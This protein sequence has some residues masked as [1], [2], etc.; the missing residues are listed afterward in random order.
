MD[1]QRV[2]P[3]D[4][5]VEAAAATLKL[6]ADP[7]RLRIVWAL[8]HGSHAVGDLAVHVGAQP[9]AVSQHLAK[10]RLAQL[11]RTERQGTRVL[12]AL[13]NDHLE[14][15]ATEALFHGQHVAGSGHPH[16]LPAGHESRGRA[17]RVRLFPRRHRG[18]PSTAP[19]PSTGPSDEL[20]AFEGVRVERGGRTVLEIDHLAL[21]DAASTAVVGPSG[22]GKSTLLRLC[23][24]LDAPTSGIVRYRGRDLDAF[25]PLVLRQEVAMVFQQPVA[26]DG[27]VADNLREGD[28]S[29]TDREV[30]LALGRVG[31]PEDLA[32]RPAAQ[33]SGGERQRLGLARSLATDPRVLLL[34]EATERAGPG[35]RRTD[36]APRRG[37]GGRGHQRRVGH[38]RPGPGGSCR[39]TGR[40]RRRGPGRPARAGRSGLRRTAPGHGGLPALG[41]GVSTTAIGL[42]GVAASLV[43]VAV[44]ALLSVH[45]RLGLERSI[46][47][48]S[49]R[50]FVQLF[51]IGGALGLVLA[52]GAPLYWSW[53]WVVAMV[54]IGGAT[55]ASRAEEVPGMF[56]LASAA[57]GAAAAASLAVIFGFGIFPLEP[58]TV[59]PSAGMLL[60]NVIAA[61][62]L[63]ARRTVIELAE[64]R[65]QIEVRLSLGQP[66]PAAVRPHVREAL[67]T[68]IGPQIETTKI[69]GLIS[70]PGTMTGLLLAG[71]DPVDAVL[72]QTAVMFLILG[73]VA[74]TSVIIG[75]GVAKRFLTVDHR[76]VIPVP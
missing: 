8:L 32:D 67:R 33:L 6:L 59:V 40:G 17:E 69:V 70:L 64:H 7:T 72:V 48:A 39:R 29:L 44:A 13:V 58:R 41:G 75:R 9:A 76:L 42:G 65:D 10:L 5:Q 15:L 16:T 68:A 62:V 25:D 43:L 28:A 53:L 66:G 14:R 30:E 74:M 36:R 34:D 1:T 38:P 71:V 27:S 35:Q 11:V 2:D 63:A 51:A 45:H 3:S 56:W 31:L 57:L 49:L 18:E 20:F 19:A 60:G 46:A 55:I 12:Y 22:S 73:S 52:D 24:R 37:T 26:L 21:T 4:D 23:N 47:W 54:A 61:T 50:A